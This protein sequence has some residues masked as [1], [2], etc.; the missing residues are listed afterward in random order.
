MKNILVGIDFDQKTEFLLEKAKDLAKKYSAKLWLLHAVPPL[1]E[2]VGFDA[3]PH[4][5]TEYRTEEMEIERKR[6]ENYTEIIKH[7]GVDAES[8]LLQG[9]TINVILEES[10]ELNVDLI[11]CGHH[12]HNLLYNLFFGSVSAAIVRNSDIPVL[13]FPL[14]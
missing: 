8:V 10:K 4:Y 13:V 11:I 2:F 1:P 6:L 3:T 5:A 7:D 12:E 9:A 14:G